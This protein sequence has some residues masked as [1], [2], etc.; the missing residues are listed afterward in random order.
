LK[1]ELKAKTNK[2]KNRLREA[3]TSN[4]VIMQQAETVAFSQRDGPWYYIRPDLSQDKR[5]HARWVSGT[6]DP[7]FTVIFVGDN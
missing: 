1:V 7:D 6:D 5:D 4:W 3:G 2:A